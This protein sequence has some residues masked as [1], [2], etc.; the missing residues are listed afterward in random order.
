MTGKHY[1]LSSSRITR[2]N[3]LK[4]G[5]LW[6]GYLLLPFCEEEEPQVR[7]YYDTEEEETPTEGEENHA[8]T[9]ENQTA[10]VP[11]EVRVGICR[12]DDIGQMLRRSVELA[13]NFPLLPEGA[14]VLIKPNVVSGHASPAT[15][16]PEVVRAVVEMVKE[17]KPRKVIVADQSGWGRGSTL[18]NLKKV[19]IYQAASEAGAEVV[20]LEKVE[21]EKVHPQGASQWEDGFR[22]PKLLDEVDYIISLPVAKTHSVATYSMA[23]KNAVGLI[24][25]VDRELLHSQEREPLF[26]FRVAET[27]SYRRPDFVVLDATRVFVSGGP[28]RGEIREPGLVI[29]TADLVAADAIG[30]ALLRTLGTTSA[31]ADL[32]IWEQ[33]QIMRA[34][35]LGL[36]TAHPHLISLKSEGVEEIE[37]IRNALVS[38]I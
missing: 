6:M 34:M 9:E 36:G 27:N 32:R 26:G 21:W 1:F 12:N 30:I 4:L 18:A 28:T 11:Q 20:A 37:D 16:N 19:G 23:L 24:H 17:Y 31:L 13:G 33:P 22:V 29:A 7:E 3:L 2:R 10:S 5:A 35:E 8:E 25:P 14:R 15:T 38:G